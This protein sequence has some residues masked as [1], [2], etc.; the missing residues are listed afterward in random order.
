MIPPG[1]YANLIWKI[2]YNFVHS[3]NTTS[4]HYQLEKRNFIND[5]LII[6]I[7][8]AEVAIDEGYRPR[9][10]RICAQASQEIDRK[11]E[12]DLR[13]VRYGDT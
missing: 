12:K 1:K 8:S 3:R 2:K 4:F 6:K 10:R 11:P 9:V 5:F 7:L 13:E